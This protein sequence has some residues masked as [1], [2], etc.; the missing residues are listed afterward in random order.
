MLYSN[1]FGQGATAGLWACESELAVGH[2]DTQSARAYGA[3]DRL[4]GM[5]EEDGLEEIPQRM[6]GKREKGEG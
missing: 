6:G 2:G 3:V 5:K 1:I 4:G